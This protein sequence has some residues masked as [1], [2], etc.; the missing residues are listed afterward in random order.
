VEGDLEG[1][2]HLGY[3]LCAVAEELKRRFTEVELGSLDTFFL[4]NESFC[5]KLKPQLGA[6]WQD[7]EE[8]YQNVFT[9]SPRDGTTLVMTPSLPLRPLHAYSPTGPLL[10]TS[11]L[12]KSKN[13]RGSKDKEKHSPPKSTGASVHSEAD[14]EES[15]GKE[16]KKIKRSNSQDHDKPSKADK[17]TF[18]IP[19]S[20]GAL[21]GRTGNSSGSKVKDHSLSQSA[22]PSVKDGESMDDDSGTGSNASTAVISNIHTNK[23]S[24]SKSGATTPTRD[25]DKDKESKEKEKEKEFKGSRNEHKDL[26]ETRSGRGN[27]DSPSL[28]HR[29]RS[30]SIASTGKT[31]KDPALNEK[32]KSEAAAD[33]PRK[34]SKDKSDK[35]KDKDKDKDKSKDKDKKGKEKDAI[36]HVDL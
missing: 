14:S 33:P 20:F 4:L 35:E 3:H 32:R 7:Q 13:S 9:P 18:G 2:K 34:K 31:D 1:A 28:A 27:S 6:R 23:L 12:S 21:F 11:G 26:K 25:K 30:S 8:G 15:G 19:M 16:K 5:K 22:P 10:D 24:D 29:G 36:K 17:K